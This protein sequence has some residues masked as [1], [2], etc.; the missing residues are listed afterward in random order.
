MRKRLLT[1]L[2][3]VVMTLSLTITAFAADGNVTYKG[4]AKEFIFE[5]GSEYSPTDI[6]ANYK[7]VMPGD[8]LTQTIHVKNDVKDN[9]KVKLYMRSLGAQLD[10]DDFLKQMTL[11]VKENGKS[12]L[13]DAPANE[14]AQLTDWVCL[15]TIYPD[16]EVMLDVTL[17]VPLSMGNNCQEQIGYLDWQF[18]AE[19]IA[20]SEDDPQNPVNKDTTKKFHIPK[21]G[22]ITNIQLLLMLMVISGCILAVLLYERKRHSR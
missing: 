14:T 7:G 15:G 5:P 18:M 16:G 4:D 21:T 1:I 2:F 19:E 8:Q 20:I 12:K 9:V 11:T 22:D 13:F 3:A 17:N 6:F 10:T